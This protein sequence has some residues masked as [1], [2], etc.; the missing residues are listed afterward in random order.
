MY[1][2]CFPRS[3]EQPFSLF[4]AHTLVIRAL[5]RLATLPNWERAPLR[6]DMKIRDENSGQLLGVISVVARLSHRAGELGWRRED[7]RQKLAQDSVLLSVKPAA[8][9]QRDDE[10][11][12]RAEM[13]Q[14][15]SHCTAAG[16]A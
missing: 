13:A 5:L 10:E 15:V 11:A 7:S 14:E 4:K 6:T 12:K 1:E 3:C 8:E 9:I 16:L 2:G